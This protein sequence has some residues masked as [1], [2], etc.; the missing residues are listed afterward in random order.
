MFHWVCIGGPVLT[1]LR[2][3]VLPSILGISTPL[4]TRILRDA[5]VFY[6]GSGLLL[7]NQGCNLC[8]AR[9]PVLPCFFWKLFSWLQVRWLFWNHPETSA[10]LSALRWSVFFPCRVL[11]IGMQVDCDFHNLLP[12]A[13]C[14]GRD[15][16][17]VC[18]SFPLLDIS[19]PSQG[20]KHQTEQVGNVCLHC[21]CV[22]MALEALISHMS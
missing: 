16:P 17:D 7:L 9:L 19:I 1:L 8:F 12:L 2:V 15:E 21:V 5:V 20:R 13:S 3:L 22:H 10:V 4:P 14:V 18:C 11:C 6:L